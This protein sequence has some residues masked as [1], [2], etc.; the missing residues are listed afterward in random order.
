MGF[1]GEALTQIYRGALLHDIGKLGIPDRI[2]HKS[3]PLDDAEWELM[4]MHPVYAYEWLR[5]IPFLRPALDIPYFH[6]ERWD[7]T[8]YPRG[9]RGEEIPLT[10]RIF[11]LV[12]SWDA[13]RSE[14]P[15]KP[16]F[17]EEQALRLIHEQ[18][19]RHFDPAV[20]EAFLRMLPE[21]GEKD[22]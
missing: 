15:Y 4:R 21:L 19:G 6:H 18:S 1:E 10:A 9:L 3:A 17:G 5:P 2:L 14:R 8:G 20:V 16:A 7:G 13:L 12:D 22:G 11:A